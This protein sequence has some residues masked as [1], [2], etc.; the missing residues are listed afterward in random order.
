[1]VSNRRHVSTSQFFSTVIT[2]IGQSG[3]GRVSLLN[4]SGGTNT[5]IAQINANETL[6]CLEKT[7]KIN[8]T[9]YFLNSYS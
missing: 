2:A 9:K 3:V 8:V 4:I 7:A 6:N 1:M 5:K